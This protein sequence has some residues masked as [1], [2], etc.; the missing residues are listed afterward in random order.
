[1]PAASIQAAAPLRA[2][3]QQ[4]AHEWHQRSAQPGRVTGQPGHG[5]TA[6]PGE[7][8]GGGHGQPAHRQQQHSLDHRGAPG[9]HAGAQHGRPQGELGAEHRQA[10]PT[11]QVEVRVGQPDRPVGVGRA[12]G[13]AG[14]EHPQPDAGEQRP[15]AAT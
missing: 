11:E 9:R 12:G 5:Q 14:H 8:P 4:R 2:A 10:H 15:A 7:Q 13:A 1:V 3:A 6:L